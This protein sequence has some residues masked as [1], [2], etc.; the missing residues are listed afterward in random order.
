MYK[1]LW[2]Y[3]AVCLLKAQFW[4]FKPKS[5]VNKLSATK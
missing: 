3:A 1:K 2:D 4:D 5:Y